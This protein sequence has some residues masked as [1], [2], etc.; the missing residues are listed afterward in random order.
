MWATQASGVYGF[1]YSWED[2]VFSSVGDLEML[3][4]RWLHRRNGRELRRS[5]RAHLDLFDV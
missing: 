4:D 5:V 1:V 3:P 2:T